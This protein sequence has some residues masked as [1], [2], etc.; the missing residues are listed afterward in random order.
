MVCTFSPKRPF[1]QKTY[2]YS[3][4]KQQSLIVYT[5]PPTSPFQSCFRYGLNVMR[6]FR[7]HR[8]G[9]GGGGGEEN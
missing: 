1:P 4:H 2:K 8:Q 6:T 9:G 3:E 5:P 7:Q